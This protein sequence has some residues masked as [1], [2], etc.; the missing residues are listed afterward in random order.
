MEVFQHGGPFLPALPERNN[1]TRLLVLRSPPPSTSLRD[2]RQ[3][4]R[5]GCDPSLF[6]GFRTVRAL[7][8]FS[9]W[10]TANLSSL[11]AVVTSGLDPLPTPPVVVFSSII[12]IFCP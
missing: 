1:P 10:Q 12:P 2:S 9:L 6:P 5:R 4:F 7:F 8:F 11:D 3:G